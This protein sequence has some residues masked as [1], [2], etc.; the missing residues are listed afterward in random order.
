MEKSCGCVIIKYGKV[1]LVYEHNAKI[2]GLPK[3]HVEDGETE[4]ETAI[5]EV[6]EEV[7]LKSSIIEGYRYTTNYIVKD[8]INKDVVYFLAEVNEDMIIPRPGEIDMAGWFT[9]KEALK[10]IEFENIREIINQAF[11]DSRKL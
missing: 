11:E 9:Q 10:I 4:E 3:G 1:L 2:W 7:G 8:N 6:K 5:R